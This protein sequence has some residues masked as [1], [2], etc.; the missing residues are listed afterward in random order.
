MCAINMAAAAVTQLLGAGKAHR[1]VGKTG[2]QPAMHQ[3][4]R[5]A[6]GARQTHGQPHNPILDLRINRFPGISELGRPEM[7]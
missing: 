7:G 6:V 1:I 4:T 5:I 3:P 2:N